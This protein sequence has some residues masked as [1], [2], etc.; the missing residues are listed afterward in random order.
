MDASDRPVPRLAGPFDAFPRVVRLVS[1]RPTIPLR[2]DTVARVAPSTTTTTI[3]VAN[4]RVQI[5]LWHCRSTPRP[6]A[7]ASAG[8]R[9]WL[10]DRCSR[11]A[12][13]TMRHPCCGRHPRRC[14]RRR[15]TSW[16]G[17]GRRGLARMS[18]VAESYQWR[19]R[20]LSRSK[21]VFANVTARQTSRSLRKRTVV[22]HW[23]NGTRR[24][25]FASD[26]Y[27]CFDNRTTTTMMMSPRKVPTL[28]RLD[29][30]DNTKRLS[31]WCYC[32]SALRRRH[33]H[34]VTTGHCVRPDPDAERRSVDIWESAARAAPPRRRPWR[35]CSRRDRRPAAA[36]REVAASPPGATACDPTFPTKK[37]R[38]SSRD[39]AFRTFEMFI[40]VL[41][42]GKMYN[43]D[44]EARAEEWVRGPVQEGDP[45]CNGSWGRTQTRRRLG[46]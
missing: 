21:V 37:G 46:Q 4:E 5:V 31:S 3:L 41:E 40:I 2:R 33:C 26:D 32:S 16:R 6:R 36:S 14:T 27:C 12:N 19:R 29:D 45:W 1:T 30:T 44:E 35:H 13:T 15:D 7:H 28:S 38:D 18:V 43:D 34:V 23:N 8:R 9:R 42:L 22:F 10:R 25:I 39:E 24:R 20:L 11:V 17:R